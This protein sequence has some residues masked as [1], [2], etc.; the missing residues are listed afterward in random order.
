MFEA[1]ALANLHIIN[2]INQKKKIPILNQDF[3]QHCCQT[4]SFSYKRKNNLADD[5]DLQDTFSLYSTVR[6]LNYEPGF[7]DYN[8]SIINY[9]GKDMS[10]A[11]TNHLIF[12]ID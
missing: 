6:P 3:F 7:K 10:I 9:I 12:I 11:T 2:L 5:I 4:V 1:Y 8:G